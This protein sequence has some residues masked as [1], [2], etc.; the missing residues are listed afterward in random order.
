MRTV[1]TQ[2]RNAK[3]EDERVRKAYRPSE[4][5]FSAPKGMIMK[6]NMFKY[7]KQRGFTLIELIMVIVILGILSAVALPRF[8][9]LQ[10]DARAAKLNAAYGAIRSAASIAKSAA[11]NKAISCGSASGTSVVME[12]TT[13]NLAYC[14]PVALSGSNG[15]AEAANVSA[16]DGY[17][18]TYTTAPNK[19]TVQVSGAS[20]AATC[21]FSYS[22]STAA[23]AAPT[24][25]AP[26]ITGC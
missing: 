16:G 9:S 2:G 3:A 19:L 20:T 21:S 23:D 11:L 5:H 10:G 25:V 8:V 4:K 18:F 15:I 1:S 6:H 12:G 13:I 17:T 26:V 14:Y 22:E 7:S 24:M